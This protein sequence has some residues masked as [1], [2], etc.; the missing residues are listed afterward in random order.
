MGYSPLVSQLGS[1]HWFQFDALGTT[2]GLTDGSGGLSDTFL[3]EAFGMSLGR[4]GTTETPYQYVGGYGYFEEPG[5]GLEQV[6]WRWLD[7]VKGRW[8]SPDRSAHDTQPAPLPAYLYLKN[9]PTTASDP[10]GLGLGFMDGAFVFKCT[11]PLPPLE[12]AEGWIQCLLKK[13]SWCSACW[14]QCIAYCEWAEFGQPGQVDA[15][16]DACKIRAQGCM[17]VG[18]QF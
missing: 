16:R 15:C 9:E 17:I 8:A 2:L 13:A 12:L 11:V 4:T 1:Q 18:Y 7:L 3:Y 5:V 6:W 14:L 10:S